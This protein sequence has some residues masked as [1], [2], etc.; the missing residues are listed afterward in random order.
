MSKNQLRHAARRPTRRPTHNETSSIAQD[1]LKQLS[2]GRIRTIW[3]LAHSGGTL[4]KEDARLVEIMQEHPEYVDLWGQLDALD[5]G[6]IL[7]DGVNPV[8]HV[9]IHHIVESQIADGD[10]PQTAETVRA[11]MRKGLERHQAIHSVGSV[12]SDEIFE[13]LKNERTFDLNR[14]IRNL[15]MLLDQM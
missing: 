6:E 7:R 15:K 9:M 2:R 1:V 8:L 14:F 3:E 12:V 11:L 5:E 10:P 13:M 4:S